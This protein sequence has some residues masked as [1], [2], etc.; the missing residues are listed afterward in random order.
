MGCCS[1]C[2]GKDGSNLIYP[3]VVSENTDLI[4]KN[5]VKN[6]KIFISYCWSDEKI[7]H[8][9]NKDLKKLKSS[10]EIN[11]EKQSLNIERIIPYCDLFIA[12]LSESY[13]ES[14]DCQ[15]EAFMAANF[16]VPI[17]LL[18]INE[19]FKLDKNKASIIFGNQ[20]EKLS[21]NKILSYS[22]SKNELIKEIEKLRN[23]LIKNR[24]TP[25][26]KLLTQKKTDKVDD[27]HIY[28]AKLIERDWRLITS[29]SESNLNNVA[30][31]TL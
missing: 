17:F 1:S 8:Q 13:M 19:K 28:F 23:H 15:R 7:A 18:S 29:N 12:C 26:D 27:V 14:F 30:D 5:E 16:H 31:S 4:D 10:L 11:L 22:L 20:I 2:T 3:D 21:I 6:F 9:L 24:Q 25:F